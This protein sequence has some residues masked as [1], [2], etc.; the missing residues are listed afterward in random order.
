VKLL[1]I[2]ALLTVALLRYIHS[3]DSRPSKVSV[4]QPSAAALPIKPSVP[5]S[6]KQ[7]ELQLVHLKYLYQAAP[8]LSVEELVQR[9]T[10]ELSES[11]IGFS[12]ALNPPPQYRIEAHPSNFGDRL[13]RSSA[14]KPVYYPLLIV[15]HETTSAASGAV[16]TVLTPHLRDNDQVSYH[17]IIRKDGTIL[18]LVDPLKRA[19]GAGNSAFQGTNGLE[20]VQTNQRLKASV[21]NFAYHISL[22]TPSDGYNE[23]PEH[24]GY[25]DAQYSSLAWLIEQSGV[26]EDRITTHRAVDRDKERQDPRSFEMALLQQKSFEMRG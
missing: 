23:E 22:E 3:V 1:V 7:L 15:L 8:Q 18:Y 10:L 26:K 19:Y 16:N 17:A 4:P 11:V 12:A 6:S 9:E 13:P 2:S 14:G 24:T 20:T 25:D 21:N 5:D